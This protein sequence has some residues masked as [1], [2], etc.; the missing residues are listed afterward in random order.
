MVI[1]ELEIIGFKSFAA[2][3]I[4]RFDHPTTAVV[5]PN[6]CGKSN[7]LDSL[8]WVLGEKS[9]KSIRGEKM[10][11]V[12]FSG[13]ENKKPAGFAQVSLTLDNQGNIFNLDMDEVKIGR[14]VYRDGQSQYLLNDKKVTRKEIETQLMDT[15]LGKSSYS[16]MEQDRIDQILSSK[17]EERRQIFEEAA[18]I[19]KFKSQKEEALKNLENAQLNLTRISDIIKELERQKNEK[20]KQAQKT[21]VYNKLLSEQKDHDLKI[22]YMTLAE[23]EKKLEEFNAKLMRKQSDREKTNQK[24][25]LLEEKA[26]QSD[27]D[28]AKLTEEL[29]K[30]DVTNQVSAEKIQQW[31]KSLENNVERKAR[32]AKELEELQSQKQ[33]V[34]RRLKEL[35]SEADKQGQLTLQVKNEIENA[36][37]TS[38]KVELAIKELEQRSTELQEKSK[39]LADKKIENL[40]TLKSNRSELQI[41]VED[42]LNA[43]QNE[44]ENWQKAEEKNLELQ[45]SFDS[46]IEKLIKLESNIENGSI[47][48]LAIK[49]ILNDLALNT[50]SNDIKNLG[51][52]SKALRHI[53][54]EEG[55]IHSRKE[56]LDKSI[57]SIEKE[58]DSIDQQQLKIK[59]EIDSNTEEKTKNIRK[60]ESILGD[61][62]SYELQQKNLEDREKSL[63]QQIEIETGQSKYFESGLKKLEIEV[64][65]LNTEEKKI[66]TG[67]DSLKAG[68]QKELTHIENIEKKIERIEQ[69]KVT[70]NETLKKEKAKLSEVFE[71]LSDLEIKIGTYLGSQEAMI[72]DIYNDYNLTYEEI[73][74][75]L[76]KSRIQLQSEKS[77]LNDIE[78]QIESLGPIN[79][80]AIE[81]LKN[82]DQLYQHNLG[83]KN[84]I[85]EARHK[86]LQVI[87]EIHSK[88][89]ELFT[90]SFNQIQSNFS[91]IFEKLF[92]GGAASIDLIDPSKPLEAGIDIKVQPPG[93]RPK[94]LRLLSGGEKALTAI[95]LM[96]GIYMVRSSPFC[97]LDEIDAPLD[98]ANVARFLTILQEFQNSTQFILITHNKKTM[99][100][101]DAIFGVTMGEPGVSKI[102]SVDLKSP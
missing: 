1:K 46:R 24:I 73:K 75:N 22:R 34:D 5:G 77:K 19:S 100:Q 33:R 7:I 63:A 47:E 60:R 84:D 20:E 51:G 28:K 3:T 58:N 6:G 12:I 78:C 62:K 39:T 42:L 26:L 9:V 41:V 18:G 40:Q 31:E 53:L 13:T 11:D 57:K 81:E 59:E 93:K 8:K 49:A 21:E 89:E 91:S 32:I 43:L 70:E 14:R 92:K 16:F 50:W 56:K 86:I 61:L 37:T 102:I 80:L 25:L 74:E 2:K 30:K 83:Q 71:A 27:E 79:P 29:H 88:S 87:N 69:K 82:I 36:E 54:F 67:I 90:N 76:G 48:L 10:E 45:K 94:S 55:G 4:V 66:R 97:V 17:P 35:K 44:K 96:F 23:I 52:I 68:I 65:N 15:G 101:A 98:D 85:A 95:A 72:Q 64:L 38:K 99:T